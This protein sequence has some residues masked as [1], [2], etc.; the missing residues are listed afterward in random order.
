MRYLG[1]CALLR[2]IK[3]KFVSWITIFF[4]QMY[5]FPSDFQN[6]IH[7]VHVDQ[8]ISSVWILGKSWSRFLPNTFLPLCCSHLIKLQSLEL[9]YLRKNFKVWEATWYTEQRWIWCSV[10]VRPIWAYKMDLNKYF[11]RLQ[12][13][14]RQVFLFLTPFRMFARTS[15]VWKHFT[16][17]L[18]WASY[19]PLNTSG[20]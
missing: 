16:C 9:T 14:P 19:P 13:Y 4:R 12:R 18:V 5:L 20:Q 10:Y 6:K 15:N 8:N 17:L 11:H 1:K 2:S 3:G 7:S